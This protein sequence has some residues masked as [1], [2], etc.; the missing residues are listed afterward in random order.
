MQPERTVVALLGFSL[1]AFKDGLLVS[2]LST[3][4][5]K[6]ARH[7]RAFFICYTRY[8]GS[9]IVKLAVRSGICTRLLYGASLCAV[10]FCNDV[11]NVK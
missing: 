9:V 10:L 4:D 7:C 3:D 1:C 6:K 2:L 5:H 11:R 8:Q